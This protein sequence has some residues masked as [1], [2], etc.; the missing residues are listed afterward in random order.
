M[1]QSMPRRLAA[2]MAVDAVGYTRLMRR[3][4]DSG[5]AILMRRRQLLEGEIQRY[6]GRV[7][8]GAGDSVLAEFA[9]AVDSVR[10]AL[11]SQRVLG[12]ANSED[13]ADQRLAFRI[14]INL[15]DVIVTDDGNLYGD[16]VNLA[17]RLETVA[18]P[19]GICLSEEAYRQVRNC[20]DFYF[21]DLGQVAV[22]NIG[23]VR[24]YRVADRDTTGM[25]TA[26]PF[27]PSSESWLR[28][29][30]G[31]SIVILPFDN[32]SGDPDQAFFCDGLTNDIT[33]DLSR[34]PDLLVIASNSA[35]ACR[36]RHRRI[37]EIAAELDVRYLLEGSVQRL[38]ERVRVNAQLIDGAT[39]H[40]IWV[41][42]FEREQAELFQLQD[43]IILRIVG[44]LPGRLR[45][46]EGQRA[47]RKDP[48]EV[49]AYEAYLRGAYLYSIETESALTHCREQ[50]ELA[51]RL[52]PSFARPWGYLAY[53][54][55]Q[56]WI[57]GW[58]DETVLT[59]AEDYARRAVSLDPNDYANHWDLAI[60]YLNT[61]RFDMA[62]EE[63]ARAANLN[64]NDADLLAEMAE[65]LVFAGESDIALR[66]LQEAM[67]RNPFH[68]DWYRWVL[69]WALFNSDRHAEALAEL[70]RINRPPQ[71]IDL[72]RA[73]ILV[74]LGRIEEA[75][76]PLGRFLEYR[77]GWN[78]AKERARIT[79]RRRKDEERWLGALAEAGLPFE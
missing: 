13:P 8:S 61:R 77:P 37:Q 19:G 14:G 47:L 15:G 65:T 76:A 45:D 21:D 16:C 10:C 18:K 29:R 35:F 54:A 49:G 57:A 6:H 17:A 60:V 22:K 31:I 2:I 23:D 59:E 11:A 74:K 62:R 27:P 24:V 25:E 42:R 69:S 71:H 75:K 5:M 55:V 73:A 48:V 40:H 34:F 41:E 56:R 78:L 66:Q 63:Y 52:D 70:D 50:F 20:G 79:F 44:S 9:S 1:Q 4:E 64:P 3:D 30:P 36:Y 58:G 38:G 46:I 26:V 67:R 53:V 68:P 51:T 33:S 7:F 32:L 28:S 72:L 43:E 39:G 12:A